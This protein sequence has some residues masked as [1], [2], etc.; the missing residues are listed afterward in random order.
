MLGHIHVVRD[1]WGVG[2][3]DGADVVDGGGG[4]DAGDAML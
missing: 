4:D 1:E 2:D 3:E